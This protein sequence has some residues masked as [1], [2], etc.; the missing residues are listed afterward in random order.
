MINSSQIKKRVNDISIKTGINPNIVLRHII[1]EFFLEK[2]EK[3]KYCQHYVIK[4]GFL[5]SSITNIDLRTTMD[6]DVTIQSLLMTKEN[7]TESIN[8]ILSVKTIHPLVMIFTDIEEIREMDQY[9]GFRATISVHLDRLKERIK[10]DFTTGDIITPSPINYYYK[11][12]LDQ[13]TL[14]IQSYNLETIIS[15]KLET[16]LSRGTFNTRLRDY[17]DIFTIWNIRRNDIDI[18]LLRRAFNNTC[19]YRINRI[20]ALEE[21]LNILDRVFM[22]KRF[23]DQWEVYQNN[24]TY[25]KN[26]EFIDTLKTIKSILLELCKN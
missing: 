13:E 14:K 17:Y 19:T 2:L 8:D 7:L 4:G 25:V 1:F 10:I 15:E 18:E 3:S 5:I 26:V 21:G 23:F 20:F 6:L 9:P 24:Y 12:I 16:I 22:D 11:K